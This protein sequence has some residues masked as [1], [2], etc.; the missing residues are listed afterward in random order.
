MKPK[1]FPERRRQRQ[2]AAIA[3]LEAQ[4]RELTEHEKHIL[5]TLRERTAQPLRDVRTKKRRGVKPK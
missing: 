2:L 3:R 5:V 4:E 1:N